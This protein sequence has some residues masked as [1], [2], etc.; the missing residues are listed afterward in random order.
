MVT[1][2][3]KELAREVRDRAYGALTAH[4]RTAD[5]L[6][7]LLSMNGVSPRM[8][9]VMLAGTYEDRDAKMAHEVFTEDDCILEAGSASGFMALYCLKKIG[10]KHYCMVEANP[11]L[12][13]MI[14]RNFALN[15]IEMPRLI[16]AAV[17]AEDG[18]TSFGVGRNFWSSSIA[19][20][21]NQTRMTVPTRSI[22]SIL[23]E[24][25][26][27]CTALLMDIE[28]GEVFIP[29]EHFAAFNK[30]VIETHPLI[31]GRDKTAELLNGLE[32]LGFQI[33]DKRGGSLILIRS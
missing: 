13:A 3:L 32:E 9:W 27:K 6:G 20:R 24:L 25:P 18:E 19:Y 1:T 22:P 16:Q 12:P 8:R 31:V 17:A 15:G 10:V 4:R 28:G 21:E 7:V 11:A 29:P 2:A 33:E 14:E 26:F 30:I 23:A 5:R